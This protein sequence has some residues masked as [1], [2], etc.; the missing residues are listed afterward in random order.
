MGAWKCQIY[1]RRVEHIFHF[2]TAL[3]RD[4]MFNTRNKSGVYAHPCIIVDI[5]HISVFN[6]YE[7]E[8]FIRYKT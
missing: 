2:F 3:T 4:I 1:F 6:I 5:T 8:C 7:Q